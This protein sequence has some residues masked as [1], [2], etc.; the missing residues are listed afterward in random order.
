MDKEDFSFALL[1]KLDSSKSFSTFEEC[2]DHYNSTC[3]EVLD[4]HAPLLEKVIKD[5]PSAPWFDSEYKA[6]RVQR[7]KAEKVWLKSRLPIDRDIFKHLRL[8]CNDLALSKKKLFF[9]DH[10]EKY[11]HSTKGLYKFVDVFLDND[12]ALKLPPTESL[13]DTVEE[14]NT[15]FN[16]KIKAIRKT[17]PDSTLTEDPEANAPADIGHKLCEF[18]KTSVEELR[19]ILKSVDIKSC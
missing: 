15:F 12:A 1:D 10:F 5:V 8:H 6:A 13:Q 2:L 17:F 7:R 3:S 19:D 14:F 4:I 16:E 18:E 11:S 9:Q